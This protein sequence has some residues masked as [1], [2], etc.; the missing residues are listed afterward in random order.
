MNDTCMFSKL[1][2]VFKLKQIIYK[3]LSEQKKILHITVEL[4]SWT[5]HH[6]LFANIEPVTD[7]LQAMI[8]IL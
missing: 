3:N 7:I 5:W 1:G 6:N 4:A 8:P 2:W